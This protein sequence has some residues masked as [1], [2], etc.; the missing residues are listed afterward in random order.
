MSW[1]SLH[2]SPILRRRTFPS[3]GQLSE[4]EESENEEIKGADSPDGLSSPEY[5]GSPRLGGKPRKEDSKLQNKVFYKRSM[6][7]D[8]A[9]WSLSSLKLPKTKEKR[10][11]SLIVGDNKRLWSPMLKLKEIR[12]RG[13][14]DSLTVQRVLES[15]VVRVNGEDFSKNNVGDSAAVSIETISSI[16]ETETEEEEE[17]N[18]NFPFIPGRTYLLS[19]TTVMCDKSI[20][21]AYVSYVRTYS[22]SVPDIS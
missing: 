15:P 7:L 14:A 13:V 8:K 6:S 18:F 21:C 16:D 3:N 4:R 20:V 1:A 22:C 9:G 19:I 2:L 10:S 17:E 12:E 11:R 5:S